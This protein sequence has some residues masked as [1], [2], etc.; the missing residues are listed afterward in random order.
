MGVDRARA[1]CYS[2]V[3]AKLCEQEEGFLAIGCVYFR[4][5]LGWK[6]GPP[7]PYPSWCKSG[8]N[9]EDPQSLFSWLWRGRMKKSPPG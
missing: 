2:R 8:P 3:G 6:R 5:D 7:A 9:P 1:Y 4:G